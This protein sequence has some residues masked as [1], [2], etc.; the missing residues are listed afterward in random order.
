MFLLFAIRQAVS[1]FQ[2]VDIFSYASESTQL[3]LS[4][5]RGN[6]RSLDM[7][8]ASRTIPHRLDV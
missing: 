7:Q 4:Y 5:G 6:S 3:T 8:A 2:Q 1:C